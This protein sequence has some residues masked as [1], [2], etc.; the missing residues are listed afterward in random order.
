MERVPFKKKI[1]RRRRRGQNLRNKSTNLALHKEETKY[2]SHKRTRRAKR[3]AAS[4][5]AS[6]KTD[7]SRNFRRFRGFSRDGRTR[8]RD[9]AG[10]ILCGYL[11]IFF[12]RFFLRARKLLLFE[13]S[14]G[15]GDRRERG[16]SRRKARDPRKRV[17]RRAYTVARCAREVE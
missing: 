3:T 10:G 7:R 5:N 11:L 6:Q 16:F 15:N 8:G 14:R 1:C 17:R 4:Q 9:F 13:P 2:V 12:S